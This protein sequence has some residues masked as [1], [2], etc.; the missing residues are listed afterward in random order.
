MNETQFKEKV[1]ADLKQLE[2]C[3]VLKTQE[4]G[5]VGVPD[6]LIC[7]KGKFVAIE[8][9]AEKGRVTKIQLH[10]LDKITAAGGLAFVSRPSTWAMQFGLIK[11]IK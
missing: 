11:G 9:K 6:L 4:R 8:L 2:G 10:T 1:M 3:Y 5:R 7:Y